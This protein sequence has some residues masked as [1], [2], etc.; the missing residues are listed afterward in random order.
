MKGFIKGGIET[1]VQEVRIPK[2]AATKGTTDRVT[3]FKASTEKMI[4]KT[5]YIPRVGTTYCWEGLC[6]KRFGEPKIRNVYPIIK[7]PSTKDGDLVLKG[8]PEILRL[9]LSNKKDKSIKTKR[10]ATIYSSIFN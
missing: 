3:F 8:D 2:Y 9:E 10:A 5:H 4:A 6:C 1:T 7:Y